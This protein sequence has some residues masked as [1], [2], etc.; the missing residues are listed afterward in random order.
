MAICNF[1]RQEFVSAQAV[2]AHLKSCAAY[3]NRPSRQQPEAISLRQTSLRDGSLGNALPDGSDRSANDSDLVRQLDQRITAER[4]R[5][6]LREVEE[7][8]A[9]MD[10]RS[11]AR[12]RELQQEADKQAEVRRATER[13][14]EAA[15]QREQQTRQTQD[16]NANAEQEKHCRRRAAIQD[17]KRE[18]IEQWLPGVFLNPALK[19]DMLRE[20]EA[21]LAR[22]PADELPHHE[23]AQIAVGVRDRLHSDATRAER[24]AQ[25]KAQERVRSKQH[26]RQHG[27]GYAECALREVDGLNG[28]D[29]VRIELRISS[30]LEAIKG[31][32]SDA[33][34]EDWVD[35]ILERE[36]IKYDEEED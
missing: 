36:G 14:Q 21:A 18:V 29:R 4:R 12:K 9:E 5:L 3:L 16:R 2:R 1:C 10:R 11:E 24:D 34:I 20:I 22:L 15:H 19:A 28:F 17:V 25:H 13:E 6:E 33:E 8:H 32:E 30:E 35:A 7:A 23:L 26:L 31:D 27:L